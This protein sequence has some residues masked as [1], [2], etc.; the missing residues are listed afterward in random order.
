MHSPLVFEK[1]YPHDL[2]SRTISSIVFWSVVCL[3]SL[4]LYAVATNMSST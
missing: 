3:L 1:E 2:A 4:S